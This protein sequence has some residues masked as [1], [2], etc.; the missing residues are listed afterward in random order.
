M[1]KGVIFDKDGTLIDF[2]AL[3]DGVG[4][5]LAP[6]FLSQSGLPRD[7]RLTAELSRSIGV[8][9]DG[10]DPSGAFACGT[11]AECGANFARTLARRG[12]HIADYEA[13]RRLCAISDAASCSDEARYD[14]VCDLRELFYRL[15][16][17]GVRLGLVTGDTQTAAEYLAD[18][19]SLRGYFDLIEGAGAGGE[20][21]KPHRAPADRFRALTGVLPGELV[22]VG[23]TAAD[24]RFARN[25]GAV[26]VAV[27]SGVG[28]EREL[29]ETAD[30][31]IPSAEHIYRL[32]LELK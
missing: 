25:A 11:Y 27:L 8:L 28:D 14:E 29:R 26:A 12:Y 32:I 19:L 30:F 24:V 18:R 31:V 15:R 10:V 16:S 3:W 22:I 20:D 23:D 5:R 9:P 4:A 13:A 2:H 17:L 21:S 7:T 1:I 6:A